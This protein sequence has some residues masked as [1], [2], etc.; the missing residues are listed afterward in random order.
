M[1][2]DP[3]KPFESVGETPTFDPNKPFEVGDAP[4]FDP[5]KPFDEA[6][7]ENDNV[8]TGRKVGG[9]ATDIA[10]SESGRLA[11]ASAG[12]A[13]TATGVGAPLGAAVY[14]VGSLASGAA[15]SLARQRI[16]RPGEDIS[17][18]EVVSDSLI[19]LIPGLKSAKGLGFVARSGTA[20]LKQ[21]AVGS[22]I[23]AGGSVVE[24]AI[25][26][27][28]LPTQE[29]L[30]SRGLSGAALGAGLGVAGE[31][32]SKAYSKFAGM[33]TRSFNEALRRGDPE[34]K[35]VVDGIEKTQKQYYDGVN[36][37]WRE[38]F[39]NIQEKY[40][41]AD[42]RAAR[43]QDITVSG[44]RVREDAPLKVGDDSQ[45]YYAKKR[46][47]EPKIQAANQRIAETA[48][49]DND[50]IRLRSNE[51]GVDATELSKK[52]D[53]Y[54]QAKHALAYN[55][56]KFDGAAGMTDNQARQVI[57]DFE[58][59]KLDQQL[60]A[61]IELRRGMSNKILD[62]LVDGGLV[63]K[64]LRNELRKKYPDYV[65]LNR[66]MEEDTLDGVIE[67]GFKGSFITNEAT[68]S[69]LRRAKGSDKAVNIK[70]NI[71]NNLSDAIRRAEVNK[72]NIAFKNLIEAPQNKGNQ[73]AKV[74]KPKVKGTR[75]VKDESPE[76][77]IKRSRGEKV[78]QKKVPIYEDAG[79]N[80][81]TIFEDGQK[82]FVKFSDPRMAKAF[83][84][85]HKAEMSNL[86]KVAQS[87]NRFVGGLYTRFNP[88]FLIPNLFRD[89]SEAFVNNISK[90]KFS[91]AIKTLAPTRVASDMN[92]IRKRLMNVDPSNPKE[93]ELYRTYDEFKKAGGSSGGL[94][95]TT[96]KDVE[97]NIAE[98]SKRIDAPIKRK[99]RAINEVISG[100]NEVV[101]DA[102]R[103]GTYRQARAAGMSVDQA[104][105]AA[106]NSSF[107]PLL[108]GS[109]VDTIRA[110]YLFANPALQGA[111]N[112]LRSMSNPKVALSVMTGLTGL[113]MAL[114][115]WNQMQDPEWR[116]KL[117]SGSGSNW[118]INKN[119]IIVTG[120][121]DD[122]SLKYL[123]VPI[124]YS[125]TPFKMAA[126]MAQR[127]ATGQ[128]VGD[129]VSV[130]AEFGQEV[131]DSYNPMGGSP[132]PTPLRWLTELASNKDGL[133][134]DIRP[135][136]LEERVMSATERIYPWT[137]R[138]QG[139]EIAMAL[140]DTLKD[141]GYETSPA[142]LLYLY[143]TWF[144]G[145]GKTVE[146]LF[147][148]SSKLS[149]GKVIDKNEIPIARRFFGDTYAEAWE[150]R[151]GEMQAIQQLEKQEGTNA[152]RTTR[153][154]D[155]IIWDVMEQDDPQMQAAVLRQ[156]LES[157]D[158]V[159]KRKV[160]DRLK[161]VQMGITTTDRARKRLGVENGLRAQSYFETIQ[162]MN[163]Q[164]AAVFLQDQKAKGILTEKV[165]ERLTN[166]I[167]MQRFRASRS[168]QN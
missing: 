71:Y 73:I 51:L 101:E 143:Q 164:D 29:E 75:L 82:F 117:K 22:V 149:N 18:G 5:S 118:K 120:K 39:N 103:F 86:L 12:A 20:A 121:N 24:S 30:V 116:A 98:L 151:N 158:S 89:R 21:G 87:Y 160:E 58:G 46:L 49:A 15:G 77:Q 119:L 4:K 93:L 1:E 130:A 44:K 48:Q 129:P 152:A 150:M 69:G 99:V 135:S 125:M 166:L 133:G 16:N 28:R 32:F 136:I 41:D 78:A 25:D 94:G 10:I 144:G 60:T 14:V 9:F 17:W 147:N 40:S 159:V 138:T 168:S 85:A 76:A 157:A 163:P 106:R 68:S 156:A 84:G 165:E 162:K 2:F 53:D 155:N 96:V 27:Q 50:F 107:D 74:E 110:L 45:N 114:D 81:L 70:E 145:P 92:I 111:K 31:A 3:T 161:Q 142:N 19:N 90:M 64:K 80:V 7:S 153:L 154:A 13:L 83:K 65:P 134:R 35:L 100:I 52:V 42:I 104:A 23:G 95:L 34:A 113:T 91:E 123:S 140:T 63:S 132:I 105:L 6:A 33:P 102:T 112:F 109:E 108:G 26:E 148:V 115:K 137:A 43:A 36:A 88:E 54:L 61:S 37:E 146:R 67:S 139:G 56:G 11:S 47:A 126:D 122:G 124:G 131:I 72:A 127:F 97:K 59:A 57:S 62:T 38:R 55:K 79:A 141:M 167:L 66:I 8:G 128:E